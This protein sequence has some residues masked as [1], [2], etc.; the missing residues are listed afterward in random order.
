[1]EPIDCTTAIPGYNSYYFKKFEQQPQL[2]TQWD[3]SGEDIIGYSKSSESTNPA[4]DYYNNVLINGQ[5]GVEAA[6]VITQ[7]VCKVTPK[8]VREW[9]K[10]TGKVQPNVS[11]IMICTAVPVYNDNGEISRY[12]N[13]Q[14]KSKRHITRE[15]LLDA[16]KGL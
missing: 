14:P 8:E 12:I 3:Y 2:F 6:Q 15:L 7:M 5:N 16:E 10:L 1:M 13:I 4:S 11:S 9:F